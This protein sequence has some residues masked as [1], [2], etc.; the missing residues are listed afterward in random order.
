MLICNFTKRYEFLLIDIMTR[1]YFLW[2]TLMYTYNFFN[3]FFHGKLRKMSELD[4]NFARGL[5]SDTPN[6]LTCPTIQC[7]VGILQQPKGVL[8]TK[9]IY[10]DMTLGI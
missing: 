4:S 9:I 6:Q 5:T 8:S 10:K 1:A 3:A 7:L 2:H